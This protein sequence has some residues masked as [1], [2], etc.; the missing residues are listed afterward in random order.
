MADQ[1]SDQGRSQGRVSRSEVVCPCGGGVS[2][3]PVLPSCVRVTSA[4]E[5]TVDGVTQ[6]EVRSETVKK[7]L[8]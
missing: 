8:S 4:L 7:G 2:F 1:A 5:E 3:G 6:G